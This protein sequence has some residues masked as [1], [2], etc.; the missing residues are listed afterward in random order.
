MPFRSCYFKEQLLHIKYILS[1]QTEYILSYFLHDSLLC[2]DIYMSV[3][4]PSI[5]FSKLII[6]DKW[7]NKLL[8]HNINL[9][10]HRRVHVVY[11]SWFSWR[12]GS[13]LCFGIEGPRFFSRVVVTM[14]SKHF[15]NLSIIIYLGIL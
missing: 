5:C 4:K 9:T 10:V 14:I 6:S 12:H 15:V 3:I 13:T 8:I 7:R 2:L 1:G 11:D